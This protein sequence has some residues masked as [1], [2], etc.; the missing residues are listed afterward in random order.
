MD[1]REEQIKKRSLLI[2]NNIKQYNF[3]NNSNQQKLLGEEKCNY[4]DNNNDNDNENDHIQQGEA[5][6]MTYN[7]I[8]PSD[9]DEEEDVNSNS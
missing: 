6:I 3:Q 5:S 4:D 1:E 8:L 7:D 9:D 2:S